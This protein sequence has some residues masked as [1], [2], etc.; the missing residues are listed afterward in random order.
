M[1][2]LLL[3]ILI[4]LSITTACKPAGEDATLKVAAGKAATIDKKKDSKDAKQ[5]S[6]K[7]SDSSADKA[8]A[9]VTDDDSLWK[10]SDFWKVESKKVKGLGSYMFVDSTSIFFSSTKNPRT[11]AKTIAFMEAKEKAVKDSAPKGKLLDALN[12]FVKQVRKGERVRVATNFQ[13]GIDNL[14][15]TSNYWIDG[16]IL[17]KK[18]FGSGKKRSFEIV[19]KAGIDKD[20]EEK[21]LTP[22]AS[23]NI[24]VKGL[25]LISTFFCEHTHLD[26][27]N[28]KK[29]QD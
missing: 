2:I 26:F 1:R 7:M 22:K 24:L 10:L 15:I 12:K 19:A 23:V 18:M 8:P 13:V 5:G 6:K 3:S 11:T 9:P 20:T 16:Y 4:S 21:K 27:K 29:L 17:G 25:Q 14:L 28:K